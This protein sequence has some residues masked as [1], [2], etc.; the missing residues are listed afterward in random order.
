[1]YYN[2]AIK[3]EYLCGRSSP[4]GIKTVFAKTKPLEERYGMDIAELQQETLISFLNENCPM[5]L[6]TARLFTT[7]LRAYI[8]WYRDKFPRDYPSIADVNVRSLDFST[9]MRENY[10]PNLKALLDEFEFYNFDEGN[11]VAPLIMLCWLGFPVTES[12]E[13]LESQID[14]KNG[15]IFGKDGYVIV[16]DIPQEILSIFRRY[17]AVSEAKIQRGQLETWYV[18]DSPYFIR[19]MKPL[20][21]NR[22]DEGKPYDQSYYTYANKKAK[23]EYEAKTGKKSKMVTNDVYWSGMLYRLHQYMLSNPDIRSR[24]AE[25]KIKAIMRVN[26][27]VSMSDILRFYDMYKR[28]FNL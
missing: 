28:A 12:C 20:N 16:R 3:Q 8:S 9:R 18:V 1:M 10:V 11:Q 22:N 25:Y 27:Q 26:S 14:L 5:G 24:D 21:S 15:I 19:Y 6:A 17:K 2:D 13:I 23:D 7:R 4:N